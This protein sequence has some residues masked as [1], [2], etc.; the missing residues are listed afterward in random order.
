MR[1]KYVTVFESQKARHPIKH[2]T[3]YEKFKS[4]RLYTLTE[5]TTFKYVLHFN[6]HYNGL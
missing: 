3:N 5:F 1:W 6:L 2:R 4:F